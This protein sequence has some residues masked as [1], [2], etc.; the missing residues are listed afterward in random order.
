MQIDQIEER[1]SSQQLCFATL[2]GGLD[3]DNRLAHI[4]L[5]TQ[6]LSLL[7]AVPSEI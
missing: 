6:G 5:D 2:P 3:F 4:P 7:S 1:V